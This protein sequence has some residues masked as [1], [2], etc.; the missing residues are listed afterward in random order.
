MAVMFFNVSGGPFSIEGLVAALGPVL[1][2]AMLGILPFI[3][4]LPETLIV[5]ELSSMLPEEGG[6]YTWVRR[7]FGP[8]WAFQNGWITW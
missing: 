8:F 6:Y 2:I 3:W 7:A 4:A 1:A 5:A